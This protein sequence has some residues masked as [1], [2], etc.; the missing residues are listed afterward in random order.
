MSVFKQDNLFQIY[1]QDNEKTREY[2]YT[3]L[4]KKHYKDE[5]MDTPVDTPVDTLVDKPVDILNQ[6]F[7]IQLQLFL[8]S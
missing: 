4:I 6:I 5:H 3:L 7:Q 8:S 1:Q 2:G